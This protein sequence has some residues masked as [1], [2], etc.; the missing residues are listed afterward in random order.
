[1]AARYLG[2][3]CH[4]ILRNSRALA[5]ADPGLTGNLLVERL[6]GAVVHQVSD[7]FSRSC[8]P[9]P[10]TGGDQCGTPPGCLQLACARFQGPTCEEMLVPAVPRHGQQ[11]DTLKRERLRGYCDAGRSRRRSTRRW[12]ASRWDGSWKQS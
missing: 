4:L 6:A 11:Q 5:D 1:M 2:L 8:G 12:A 3:D 9:P 7:P 10:G